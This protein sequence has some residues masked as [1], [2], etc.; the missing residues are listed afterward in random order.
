MASTLIGRDISERR[1]IE[2]MLTR[3]L[4]QLDLLARTGEMLIMDDPRSFIVDTGL[5]ARAGA[6]V[7]A[8]I[9]LGYRMDAVGKPVLMHGRGRAA[10]A[11]LAPPD[12]FSAMVAETARDRRA[13]VI[14]NLDETTHPRA[15]ALRDANL[16]CFAA[17]PLLALDS[18]QAVAAFACTSAQRMQ[19]GDMQVLR[20]I[21]DQISATLGR[22]R[23]MAE[24]HAREEA[25][26]LEDRRKDDFIATLAHE[27]RNPLAPI[28]NAVA[29]LR[30]EPVTGPQLAWCRDV[31]ERQG[32]HLSVLLEDLLDVSR[33]TRNKIRLRRERVVLAQ[34]IEH[35]LETTRPLIEAQRHKLTL[36]LPKEPIEIC[37]DPVR[38]AQVLGNLLN[39]AAKYTDPGG[40]IA[41]AVAADDRELSIAVR[42]N[43]IGIETDRLPEVFDMFAQLAPAL[44]R[45]RGGLGIGLALAQGLT[46]LH[47]GGIEA[48]SEGPGTGSEFIIH[49]PLSAV[50]VGS[51]TEQPRA[52]V[53]RIAEGLSVLVIDDNRDAAETLAALLHL[54]GIT[55]R[56]AFDG[57]EGLRVLEQWR[58]AAAVIDIGM[59]RLN[60]YALC[61]LIRAQPWGEAMTLVACTGWGQERDRELS[62][63]AGFDRHL[64]KPIDLEE[65]LSCLTAQT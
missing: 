36:D 2:A 58:P 61:R 23:L 20:T 27:L 33:V 4:G 49:L 5:L 18:V 59:P 25:L 41:I 51:D 29:I 56:T 14:E 53:A 7:G 37:V 22:G 21:C 39:N 3:R 6:A 8:D 47:G 15:A 45:S 48:R 42:D 43:G 32:S 26:R 50:Q 46:A 12:V 57:L 63:D 64:V 11:S 55:V 28:L 38:L 19:K 10:R 17:F 65:L 16:T 62:R 13:V 40:D 31:I 35:A 9:S 24:L 34:L 44:E 60:G 30:S 52:C 54:E 1:H